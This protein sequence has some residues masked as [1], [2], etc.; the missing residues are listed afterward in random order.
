MTLT[1][2]LMTRNVLIE[3]YRTSDLTFAEINA[4][5]TKLNQQAK[6]N[7]ILVKLI[8]PIEKLIDMPNDLVE[9]KIVEET[10]ED[11]DSVEE[12]VEETYEDS[13]SE[14]ETYEDSDSIEDSYEDSV[15]EVEEDSYED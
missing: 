10:Y 14:E 2:Y 7:G 4:E 15:E 9:E 5:I 11:S 8:L 13:D 6:A 3:H 1:E 12:T